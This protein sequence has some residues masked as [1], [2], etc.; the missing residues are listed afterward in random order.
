MME[1]SISNP[2][3][4]TPKKQLHS[5]NQMNEWA[6]PFVLGQSSGANN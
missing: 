1:R 6:D 5:T 3:Q 4:P 2:L